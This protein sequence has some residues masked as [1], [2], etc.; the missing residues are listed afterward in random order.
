M[1]TVIRL[2]LVVMLLAG[3]AWRMP[4][5]SGQQAGKPFVASTEK[6]DW[7]SYTGDAHGTRYSPLS[8]ITAAN[9]NDLEVAWRFKTD[10]LGSRPEYKLEGTP[11]VVNGTLYTTAGT[12][13][14]VI[15]LDAATGELI[16]VHRYPEGVR[17]ANAPRQLSGRGLAYWTDGK[18]DER[19]LYVTPGYRLIAL[20]ARTGQPVR[21]FGKDGVVDLKVGVVFG[22]GQQIDLETGEIGLHATP[23]VVKD[24]VLIGSA[25]KEGMTVRTSNN[26]KG[27]ARG[28][29]A[30]TGKLLW[31]FNTI[32][33]PGDEGGDTWLNN[34]WAINGNTGVWSQ[35]TVDE[36][37]GLVY[38]P[39][40]D[41]TSDYY[42]A[43]RPGNNLFGESLVCVDLQTGKRK[44]YF[45]FAHHP[46]WDHDISSAPIL[47]DVTVNGRP[48]K[49]VAVPTKQA[50]LFVFDRVTGQPIWPIEEK[51]VP[52]GDVPG[53]WYSPT[54]PHPPAA[55]MYG[56]NSVHFPDDLIDFTPELRAQALKQ[57]ERY[58][59][60]N[61]V[62][63]N[64]PMVGDVSGL[65]GAITMGAANGGT[66]WPGGGYDPETHTVFVQAATASIAA[67][68]VAPPPEG[69]SD[70]AYQAGVVGQEFRERLAAGTGT[71]AD[72]QPTSAGRGASGGR[73]RGAGPGRA[74]TGA[75]SSQPSGGAP[76]TNAAGA[77]V[78][79][80]AGREGGGG[81]RGGRG[82]GGEGGL[83]VQ[84]LPII[85]PPYGVLAAIDLDQ[86]RLRWRVPHGD[87]PDAVR[88]APM[89]KG[90]TIPKTGQNTSVGLVVTKTLVILG[91][92]QFTTT[93]EHPRGAMLRAY[94]KTTGKEVGAIFMPAPQS[95]SPMTYSVNGRQFIVVAVSG[96]PY[97]GEY[98]SYA[99]PKDGQ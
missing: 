27:L 12:R 62:V 98:I 55:L 19:I 35:I 10:N 5:V 2:A 34:S 99:L 25:M 6:G 59:W 57:I 26:T 63:Y 78:T 70:M 33:K 28:F 14:S 89:L 83:T 81:G 85:K 20:D 37:L 53:E 66:N 88:N 38:L 39:V 68:S 56:H 23:T 51:P 22:T 92:G 77:G 49:V 24:T 42:G 52:R 67:E 94:D 36:E 48:R 32:A 7:P 31:T 65:L 61:D 79:A 75:A 74:G 44:W 21:T 86:G 76:A 11:L 40:E 13:R 91:D 69:F 8:Q 17:G 30:R 93:A 4:R 72:A 54:Q 29:D 84:G 95:G 1:R 82:G 41:P 87:T 96:G 50:W 15:A 9:F 47:A 90:L 97:S 73:G 60:Q 16:W 3:A 80:G 71:Y 64:P 45:Q 46:I 58:R 18:G 43:K